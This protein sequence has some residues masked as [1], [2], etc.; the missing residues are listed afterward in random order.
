MGVFQA[1]CHLS[2]THLSSLCPCSSTLDTR[3]HNTSPVPMYPVLSVSCFKGQPGHRLFSPVL[4][5]VS[6]SSISLSLD[7]STMLY[8]CQYHS[9][10]CFPNYI[11]VVRGIFIYHATRSRFLKDIK[12]FHPI[13]NF[14]TSS[15]FSGTW[16]YWDY[17]GDPSL[18]CCD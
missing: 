12:S 15:P 10:H 17:C 14:C 11:R 16:L 7:G 6:R 4:L 5:S 18:F 9:T 2:W 8:M 3:S 1:S 13:L